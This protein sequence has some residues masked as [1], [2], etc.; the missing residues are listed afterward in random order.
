MNISLIIL[1]AS[2]IFM[3]GF[4]VLIFLF[5]VIRR[6]V[7]QKRKAKRKHIK[8]ANEK[9]VLKTLASNTDKS[10]EETADR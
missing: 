6:I 10:A 4:A 3:L 9:D 2:L 7:L 8:N 5:I 1:T